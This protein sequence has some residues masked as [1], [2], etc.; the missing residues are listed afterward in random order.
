MT[1]GLVNDIIALTFICAAEYLKDTRVFAFF[2]NFFIVFLAHPS[3][4]LILAARLLEIFNRCFCLSY[5]YYNTR[6]LNLVASTRLSRWGRERT[7]P[8]FFV[9]TT[10]V[11]VRTFSLEAAMH[12]IHAWCSYSRASKA[13]RRLCKKRM[14]LTSFF[15]L[16]KPIISVYEPADLGVI[17]KIP[18]KYLYVLCSSSEN[19]YLQIEFWVRVKKKL[20]SYLY[21]CSIYLLMYL[22]FF[23]VMYFFLCHT[24]RPLFTTFFSKYSL[25][26]HAR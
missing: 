4:V 18:K 25:R 15:F 5:V 7:F 23:Y 1:S 16:P 10:H 22:S 19:D 17:S 21:F 9:L 12:S 26:Y 20:L 8:V 24:I 3:K 14:Y 2:A 13:D 11:Y 6:T